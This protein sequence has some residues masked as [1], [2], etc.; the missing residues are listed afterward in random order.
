MLSLVILGFAI[1]FGVLARVLLFIDALKIST[2]WAFG[3]LLPFGPLFFRLSYPDEAR[4]SMMFR[5]ATIACIGL[6][7]I[8]GP[9]TALRNLKREKVSKA[10]NQSMRPG[11]NVYALEQSNGP[12]LAQR[13]A[14]NDQEM[15]RLQK[16]SDELRLRKRD[17]LHSDVEGNRLY[18]ADLALY[19]DA[20]A[21]ATAERKAFDPTPARAK[22]AS[23]T[24]QT[25]AAKK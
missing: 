9:G 11:D 14:A 10:A 12:T 18:A 13:R 5:L 1:A 17:L 16:W 15:A 3:T 7:L 22:P 4:R 6:Y 2:G 20:L 24:K 21:K 8:T 19:N 25:N 23:D